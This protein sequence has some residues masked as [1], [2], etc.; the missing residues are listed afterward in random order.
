MVIKIQLLKDE[1]NRKNHLITLL[2]EQTLQ[3]MQE[4]KHFQCI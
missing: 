3:M 2:E 1:Y 4:N